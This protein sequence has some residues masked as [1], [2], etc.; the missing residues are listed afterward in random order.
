MSDAVLSRA[1]L[2]G[3]RFHRAKLTGADWLEVKPGAVD[4]SEATLGQCTMLKA[5]FSGARFTGADLSDANLTRA[6][7]SGARLPLWLGILF[8]SILI[9]E[10]GHALTARL[11]GARAWV[12]L[13]SFG[14]LAHPDRPLP[15]W[16]AIAMTLAGP[17]AGFAFG[18]GGAGFATGFGR[19]ES[20][21]VSNPFFMSARRTRL[22]LPTS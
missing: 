17:F 8:V 3:A 16:R 9:H 13:Y 4:L 11:F 12:Q 19:N 18:G 22:S 1:E 14:G 6:D 5:D 7:L 2:S 15:K 10:L 21:F 20:R